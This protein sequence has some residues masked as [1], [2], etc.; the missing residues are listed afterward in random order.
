MTKMMALTVY[1]EEV[2]KLKTVMITAKTYNVL[3]E[4]ARQVN[5]KDPA[6]KEYV[7]ADCGFETYESNGPCDHCGSVRVVL[8]SVAEELFGPDWRKAFD[9]D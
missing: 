7:C 1:D 5:E 8:Q 9:P 6:P 3:I 4:T 2:G